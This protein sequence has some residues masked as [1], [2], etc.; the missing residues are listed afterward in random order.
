MQCD[1]T[2]PTL[3]SRLCS[4]IPELRGSNGFLVQVGAELVRVT[5][6]QAHPQT[7]REQGIAWA[8][9]GLTQLVTSMQVASVTP[10][11]ENH[12]K[13]GAWKYTDFS[14]PPE[15]FLQIVRA[16]RRVGLGIHFDT[17]NATA[18]A[19]DPVALLDRVIERVVSVHVSDT[20]VR[21]ALQPVLLGT[22][23]TPFTPLFRRLKR[24]KWDGWLCIEEASFLG[25]EGIKFAAD[26]VRRTWADA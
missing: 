10:V 22:G 11:Y 13:P 15:I 24:A 17:A 14:E 12:S 5:A 26:F 20:A 4:A 16:T 18:F 3:P 23:L 21:G 6:G 1:K 25:L 7:S 9:D 2:T 8:V 19:D